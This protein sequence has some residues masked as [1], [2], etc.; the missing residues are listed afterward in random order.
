MLEVKL[1]ATTGT[2]GPVPEGFVDNEVL[3]ELGRPNVNVPVFDASKLTVCAMA[4]PTASRRIPRVFN[5]AVGGWSPPCRLV[6]FD[7]D[8]QLQPGRGGRYSRYHDSE[9]TLRHSHSARVRLHVS[10]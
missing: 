6:P 4:P 7:E 9:L 2:I 10:V 5:E 3:T 8:A 1:P